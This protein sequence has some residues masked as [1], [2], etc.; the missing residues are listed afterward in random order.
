MPR[1]GQGRHELTGAIC[2]AGF[3][4]GDRFVVGRWDSS[5]VGPMVDVMW[6]RPGGERIL[7]VEQERAAEVITAVYRFDR[8][9]VRPITSHFDG[10]SLALASEDLELSMRGG[11]GWRLPFRR[12]RSPWF[13][14]WV[15]GLPAR[16]LLGVRTFGVSPTG[17]QEW[18]RAD[19]YRPLVEAR[20]SV[21]GAELG[22]WVPFDR[23][24]RFGFS[25]PP[26]RPSLVLV[27]PL[28]FDPSGRLDQVVARGDGPA[29]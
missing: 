23:P 12:L 4:S 8:V 10:R 13:T 5:P 19:Q 22:R 21:A 20:A 28:L 9:V 18:Y 2:S 14:R 24:V 1:R 26:R 16:L 11:P 15:E 27:R 6:A 3:V 25:E 17:V 29:S 7:I